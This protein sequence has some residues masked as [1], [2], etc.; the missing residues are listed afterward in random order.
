MEYQ[1][2]KTAFALAA[3]GV[4]IVVLLVMLVVSVRRY[5]APLPPVQF[6]QA[7]WPSQVA[8]SSPAVAWPAQGSAAVLIEGIG[9]VGVHADDKPR[10]LA[11]VVKMMTALVI[12]EAHPLRP[13]EQG[14]TVK[15]TAA[16]VA[17]YRA[18][19]ADDQSAVLVVE[20]EELT[21][22]QLLEGLLLPSANNFADILARWDAGSIHAFVDKMNARAAAL[23]MT[24]TRYVDPSGNAP[25]STGTARD[26]LLLAQA[27][28]RN[29]IFAEIV[30][31]PQTVLPVVGTVYNVNALIGSGGVIGV[32]TGS[33]PEAGGCFVVAATATVGGQPVRVFGA[34]L[35]TLLLSDAFK[36]SQELI[37]AA[38][39]APRDVQVVAPGQEVGE[40]T[41]AWGATVPVVAAS[42][43]SLP[44][45]A[46]LPIRT[47]VAVTP[48]AAGAGV[49]STVG[50]L[51]VKVGP[52]Q[53][54]VSVQT[55]EALEGP[56]WWWRLTR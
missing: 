18:A 30:A 43:A 32:K 25:A 31:Q 19:V 6:E 16:D 37:K 46:G 11:S 42:S 44:A 39:A 3:T 41:T 9:T 36:A 17:A 33:G 20:G 24:D 45:W 4:V 40:L 38:I 47:E 56:G 49:G 8:G 54:S 14:S 48:P 5:L 35:G 22:Y 53:R 55:A 7:E 26:Q 2:R 52:N 34:V 23:G 21:E 51:A 13:G 15:I 28:M 12:L 27:A 29:D 50:T 1:P 10:P